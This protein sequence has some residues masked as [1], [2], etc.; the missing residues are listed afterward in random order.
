MNRK[1]LF[2]ALP[3]L[4]I[5]S[6]SIVFVVSAIALGNYASYL[7]G[8][9]FYWFFW[10][11]CVP[12]LIGRKSILD[13][14]RSEKPFLTGRN[15][16]VILLF[17]STVIVPL[18]M[19]NTIQKV[20][21]TPLYLILLNILLATINGCCEEVFW[22]GFFVK[23]FPDSIVWGIV[24]P[25]IFFALWHFAPQFAIPHDNRV[26][27]VL[28]TLPLGIINGLVAYKTRSAKWSAIG[29]SI[30]GVL[31]VAGPPAISLYNLLG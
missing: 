16:W 2:L 11:L 26:A 8:I 6:T 12:T 21:V 20:M 22:R 25:S 30:G 4:L 5:L 1:V 14:M 18:F 13:F 3:V 24:I 29:H 23:E 17:L 7:I 28:S 19:Y 10:C 27:F 9:S 15:W 31:A